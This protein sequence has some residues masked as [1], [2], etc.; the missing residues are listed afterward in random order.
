MASNQGPG[1]MPQVPRPA[2]SNHLP[3]PAAASPTPLTREFTSRPK[4]TEP[5]PLTP[6]GCVFAKSC[7]LPNGITD[8]SSPSGFIPTDSLNAYG[9]LTLLGSSEADAS[10]LL[11]LKK[12]GGAAVP[13]GLGGLSLSGVA[14]G[15]SCVTAGVAGGLLAGLVALFWSSSLGDSALY[16]QEQLQ[17]LKQ[18]RIR[19]RLHVEQQADGTLKGYGYYTGKKREWETIDVV[20]FQMRG[21]QQIADFGNGV[22]LIWTPASNPADTSG[23]PALEAAPKT[24]HIWIYPP[25][26]Q[27][28]HMIVNPVHPPD[29]KD[30]ILVFPADSGVRPLYIVMN[31]RLNSGVVTGIGEDVPGIWLAGAGAGLGVPIPTRI[32]NQL[33]GQRFSRFDAFRR[34]F[35]MTVGDD[36][37]LKRQFSPDNIERMLKGN[38]P[39]ARHR[40]AH[41]AKS[42]FELHH[43]NWLCAGGETYNI[44]NLRVNTPKN[45]S[46]IHRKQTDENTVL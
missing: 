37:E 31:V 14:G 29:Y 34:A 45:H 40:D 24:P 17:T 25:T 7:N 3:N 1:P 5:E 4:P 15:A 33:I 27:A 26:E 44:D 9:N 30:F 16:T 6:V 23:I 28:D 36:I 43:V 8:Y 2:R 46:H 12:I 18:A 42:S 13:T 35:W 20:Q 10:G 21:A 41:G 22:E 11:S 39:K 19:M 38:A 32:A